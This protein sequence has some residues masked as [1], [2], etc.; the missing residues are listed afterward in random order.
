[1]EAADTP[2]GKAVRVQEFDSCALRVPR[3]PR[4]MCLS[5]VP[6]L[7]CAVIA[8]A[9]SAEGGQD[10]PHLSALVAPQ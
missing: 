3:G 6:C 4:D 10:G 5:C 7:D 1:M 2:Q 9:S 8:V